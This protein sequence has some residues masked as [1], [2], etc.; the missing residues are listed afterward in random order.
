MCPG[1][2]KVCQEVRG[3]GGGETET[4]ASV[5]PDVDKQHLAARCAH[6]PHEIIWCCCSPSSLLPSL[7]SSTTFLAEPCVT[8]LGPNTYDDKPSLYS[9]NPSLVRMHEQMMPSQGESDHHCD[10]NWGGQWVW[11]ERCWWPHYP[12][13]GKPMEGFS[14]EQKPGSTF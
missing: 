12:A 5:L 8:L 10:H 6:P 7:L 14:E 3:A 9:Q 13:Q 4:S 11:R 2:C 1:T